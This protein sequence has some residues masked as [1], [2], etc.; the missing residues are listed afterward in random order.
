MTQMQRMGQFREQF[1]YGQIFFGLIRAELRVEASIA[2]CPI[3]DIRQ[4]CSPL[5]T[6]PYKT[7]TCTRRV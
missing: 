4:M 6:A 2:H 7:T 5:T 1:F 3:R